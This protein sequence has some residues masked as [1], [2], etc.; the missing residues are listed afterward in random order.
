MDEDVGAG[1]GEDNEGQMIPAHPSV[2]RP[3]HEPSSHVN[4]TAGGD[5]LDRRHKGFGE[6]QSRYS[7]REYD[8][9]DTHIRWRCVGGEVVPVVL[10]RCDEQNEKLSIGFNMATDLNKEEK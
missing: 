1:E 8:H 9:A 4:K 2:P 6:A 3:S 5:G 7:F 10:R